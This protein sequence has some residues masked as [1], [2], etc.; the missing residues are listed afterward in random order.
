MR[1]LLDAGLV[2]ARRE[3]VKHLY[4]VRPQGFQVVEAFLQQFWTEQLSALKNESES[5]G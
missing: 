3:G 1:T 4:A 5:D 2:E